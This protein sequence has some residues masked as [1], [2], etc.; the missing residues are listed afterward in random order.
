MSWGGLGL[1][2]RVLVAVLVSPVLAALV[3]SGAIELARDRLLTPKWTLSPAELDRCELEPE[4]WNLQVADVLAVWAYN[5]DG[6]S[7]NPEAPPLDPSL[8]ERVLAQGYAF[9]GSGL[10][11]GDARRVREAGP[12]AIVRLRFGAAPDFALAFRVGLIGGGAVAMLVVLLL[13]LLLVVQPLLGRIERL[14]RAALAVGGAA[15]T[16]ALDPTGDALAGISGVLDRSHQRIRADQER[17]EQRQRDLE[18]HLADTAHDL[19]TPL[20]SLLLAVQ[21]LEPDLPKGSP[22]LGRALDDAEYVIALVD[23]LHQA[24]RLR[25]GIASTEGH[26]DLVSIVERL[27]ARFGALGLTREVEVGTATPDAPVVVRGGPALAERAIANLIHNAVRHGHPGGHVAVVL[28][29]VAGSFTLTVLDDGPG[30]PEDAVDLMAPTFLLDP[31][32]GRSRGLGLAITAAAAERL[33]WTLS[34]EPAEPT[35]LRAVITGATADTGS[36]S[37]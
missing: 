25:T 8:L 22:A 23:N 28:E 29:P 31:A 16:P 6:V 5:M 19:R 9:A 3:V 4:S 13:A 18:Q 7:A 15:Y 35:G 21:E 36:S 33:G 34:L 11:R 10:A 37:P 27:G 20:A 24:S 14:S 2:G 1:R 17:L 12:C 26:C 30:L 32:R